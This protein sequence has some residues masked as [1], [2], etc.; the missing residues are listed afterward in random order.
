MQNPFRNNNDNND[1]DNN[2]MGPGGLPIPPNYATMV[3]PESGDMRIAKV[4]FSYT[5]LIFGWW[6]PVFRSDWYNLLCMLGLSVGISMG[7]ASFYHI[8]IAQTFEFT[9]TIMCVVW[10]FLYNLMYFRHLANR[11]FKPADAHSKDILSRSRYLK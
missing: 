7:I 11:G 1:D 9:N 6:V 4:G 10:G 8:D 2:G 5:A 3:H